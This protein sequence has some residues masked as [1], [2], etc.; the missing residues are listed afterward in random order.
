MLPIYLILAL[1]ATVAG[2]LLVMESIF[3]FEPPPSRPPSVASRRTTSTVRAIDFSDADV[4]S[5]GHWDTDFV[6]HSAGESSCDY[7]GSSGTGDSGGAFSDCGDSGG[8]GGTD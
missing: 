1:L 4:S 7:A 8:D 3:R 5:G 2:F 6:L